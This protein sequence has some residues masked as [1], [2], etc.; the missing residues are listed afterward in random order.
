MTQGDVIGVSFPE[1]DTEEVIGNRNDTPITSPCV[2]PS[3][4]QRSI[5]GI[6]KLDLIP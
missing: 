6:I 1:L 5:H 4:G 2:I 3:G